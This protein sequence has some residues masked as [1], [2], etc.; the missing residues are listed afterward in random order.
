MHPWTFRNEPMH[1]AADYSGDPVAE[2]LQFYRLGVD[3]VFSDFPDTA[4]E[5]RKQIEHPA[6]H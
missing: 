1:L 5:A 6:S 2:Y 3:G 4:V